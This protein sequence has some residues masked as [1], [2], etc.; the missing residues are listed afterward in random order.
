MLVVYLPK[1]FIKYISPQTWMS[2]SVAHLL[3]GTYLA[4]GGSGSVSE[5]EHALNN[6]I[7]QGKLLNQR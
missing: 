7:T 6:R 3:I 1:Y 4:N 5:S 2:Q